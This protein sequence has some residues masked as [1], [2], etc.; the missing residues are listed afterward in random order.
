MESDK[1]TGYLMYTIDGCPYCNQ[2]KALFEHYNVQYEVV[3]DRA[4]DWDTY[5]GIYKVHQSGLELIG[6]FTELAR[7]SYEHGL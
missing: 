5:P 7:Y 2:A 3:Y 1:K 6:G 4:P